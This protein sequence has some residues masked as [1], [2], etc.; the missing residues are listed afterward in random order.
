MA[1]GIEYHATRVFI[2]WIFH[3]AD[4]PTAEHPV[5]CLEYTFKILRKIMGMGTEYRESSAHVVA[6]DDTALEMQA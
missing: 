1:L 2:F 3:L 5:L 6:W 4:A